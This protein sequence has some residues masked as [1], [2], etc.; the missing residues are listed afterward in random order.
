MT[1][2]IIQLLVTHMIVTSD[3]LEPVFFIYI[4]HR[5]A[6]NKIQFAWH[7]YI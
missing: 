5:T 1:E 3:N 4:E 7:Y 2:V 6:S